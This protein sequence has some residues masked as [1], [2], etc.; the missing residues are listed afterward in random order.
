MNEYAV[1]ESPRPRSSSTPGNTGLPPL[2]SDRCRCSPLP[3]R[4]ANGFG[5]KVAIMPRSAASTDSR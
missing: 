3:V 5:M 2:V 1:G 4:S